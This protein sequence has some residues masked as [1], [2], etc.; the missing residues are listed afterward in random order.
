[1]DTELTPAPG[2]RG[3]VYATTGE[4]YFREAIASAQTVRKMMP[5][6]PIVIY[7]EQPWAGGEPFTHA[8]PLRNYIGECLDKIEPL[9]N[10][11]FERTLFLDCDTVVCKPC[12]ELFDLLD[13]YDF[14]AAAEPAR[15]PDCYKNEQIPISFGE[16]NTGVM[17]YRYNEAVKEF[18]AEWLRLAREMNI[19]RDQA[20][21]RDALYQSSIRFWTLS[22]EYNF[23]AD[24]PAFMPAWTELKILHARKG[25]LHAMREIIDSS[26]KIRISLPGKDRC[27]PEH[28]AILAPKLNKIVQWQFSLLQKLMNRDKGAAQ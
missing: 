18:F 25:D 6:L 27:R 24:Y 3:V 17:A 21:F 5:D 8:F 16:V 1:M 7:S 11:H 15:H 13:H 14:L 22:P 2:S 12:Y 19:P 28:F 10:F 9:I 23:R 20:A 26:N 4:R